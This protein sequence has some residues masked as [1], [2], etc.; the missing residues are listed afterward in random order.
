[1]AVEGAKSVGL[2]TK[3][4]NIDNLRMKVAWMMYQHTIPTCRVLNLDETCCQYL[5]LKAVVWPPAGQKTA[6]FLGNIKDSTTVT[7]AMT[8]SEG[9]GFRFAAQI[10]H[11]GLTD[12]EQEL[13]VRPWQES[14]QHCDSPNG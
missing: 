12:K 8:M 11:A 2:H 10:L 14:T 7:A 5:P 6:S 1:M 13:P 3:E 4:D 9:A